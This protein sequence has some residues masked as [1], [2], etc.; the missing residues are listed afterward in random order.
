[1]IEPALFIIMLATFCLI[2]GDYLGLIAVAITALIV[3]C[4]MWYVQIIA[5][6]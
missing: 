5:K 4:G 1:M 3:G 6:R 2:S